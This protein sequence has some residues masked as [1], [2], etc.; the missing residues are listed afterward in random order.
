MSKW[1][2]K[3]K[4]TKKKK[5]IANFYKNLFNYFTFTIYSFKIGIKWHKCKKCFLYITK[6]NLIKFH[7]CKS[8]TSNV[9][10][11]CT[12]KRRENKFFLL[13]AQSC[14]L[15]SI[16]HYMLTKHK[17]AVC[18]IEDLSLLLIYIYFSAV[19][20]CT[21]NIILRVP[22]KWSTESLETCFI[23]EHT[24]QPFIHSLKG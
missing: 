12:L 17:I 6:C 1:Y 22:A 2:K 7:I 13:I 18:T 24:W 5:V 3:I 15:A 9:S 11:K 14:I 16:C 4:L 21:A 19:S 10:I 23:S 8:T 20:C